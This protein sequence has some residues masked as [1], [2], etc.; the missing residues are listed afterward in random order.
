M[1]DYSDIT[2][3]NITLLASSNTNLF[4]FKFC[5]AEPYTY[6][7]ALPQA[8]SPALHTDSP[9]LSYFKLNFQPGVLASPRTVSEGDQSCVS[10]AF[11]AQERHAALIYSILRPPIS[12]PLC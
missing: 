11:A 5:K 2:I 9:L 3:I 6:H 8:Q 7:L 10:P 1:Q 12:P 4:S